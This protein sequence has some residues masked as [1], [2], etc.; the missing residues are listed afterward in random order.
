MAFG[1]GVLRLST[2][3]FWG[4]T[5]REMAA[6]LRGRMPAAEPMRRGELAELIARYPD[7]M[8]R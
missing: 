6:A 2:A 7:R 3:A 1:F 8:R 4:M 5:L